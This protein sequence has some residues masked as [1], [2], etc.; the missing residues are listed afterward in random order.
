MISDWLAKEDWKTIN[1]N[2]L[3]KIQMIEIEMSQPKQGY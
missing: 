3:I 2:Q 1:D